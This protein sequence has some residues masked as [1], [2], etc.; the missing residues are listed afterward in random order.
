ML[1]HQKDRVWHDT[2]TLD[3]SCF[4]F[5]TDQER[6][7]LPKGTEAPERERV[8]IY[9]RK[10]MVTIVWNPTEL[11]RIVALPKGTK[12]NTD[13][14]ISHIFDP[15]AEWRRNQVGGSARTL[16]VHADNAR[17]H[18]A[19]MDNDFLAGNGMKRAPDP[20]YSP[21]LTPCDFYLFGYIKGRLA[22]ASFQEPDQLL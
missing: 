6:I 11:Y 16:H 21:D 2:V 22:D 18:T 3:E 5:T 20:P 14:Y 4:D 12:F 9:S 13:Y 19:K 15:L 7:W 10:V 1:Q 8:T 17:P